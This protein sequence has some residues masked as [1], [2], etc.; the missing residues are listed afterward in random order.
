METKWTKGIQPRTS[1][2]CQRRRLGSVS[3]KILHKDAWSCRWGPGGGQVGV[4]LL[5]GAGP[6][7][8]LAGR[9]REGAPRPAGRAPVSAHGLA[10]KTTRG[11]VGSSRQAGFPRGHQGLNPQKKGS[12]E[13]N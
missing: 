11:T 10:S 6:L 2:R 13:T 3:T 8:A 7:R 1:I 4:H 5:G 9:S 12:E